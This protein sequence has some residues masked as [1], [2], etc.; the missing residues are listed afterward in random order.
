MSCVSI[1]SP[2]AR[3]VPRWSPPGW[4]VAGPQLETDLRSVLLPLAG[5][6][7]LDEVAAPTGTA[8]VASARVPRLRAAT[9]PD[10]TQV[11]VALAALTHDDGAVSDA[12]EII[13][14]LRIAE[15]SVVFGWA[16]DTQDTVVSL[17]P[18]AVT[19]TAGGAA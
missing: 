18:V 6:K 12:A 14:D 9:E 17:D 4:A 19:R 7:Q 11:F 2:A 3:S 16:G 15:D 5:W 8:H 13:R 10:S 1:R